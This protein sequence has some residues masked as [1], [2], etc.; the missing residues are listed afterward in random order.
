M[1]NTS[2]ENEVPSVLLFKYINLSDVL[3]SFFSKKRNSLPRKEFLR[4]NILRKFIKKLK[5]IISKREILDLEPSFLNLCNLVLQNKEE[6]LEAIDR[7]HLPYTENRK[8][9]QFK[10]FN[11]K[12]CEIFFKDRLLIQQIFCLFIEYIFTQ[13]IQK[14]SKDIGVFCCM[15][16]C[17]SI[18][19][20]GLKYQQLKL[21]IVH[22]I[23]YKN[24]N[25]NSL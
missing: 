12:F 23:L 9:K 4:C 3:K 5:K 13:S 7:D 14:L 21:Y 16:E 6:V 25:L 24:L 2:L 10:S 17:E 15:K 8:N 11:D 1:S 20:C 18:N 19:T 22:D